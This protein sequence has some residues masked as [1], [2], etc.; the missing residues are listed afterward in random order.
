MLFSTGL[1]A[2]QLHERLQAMLDELE[3]LAIPHEQSPV[4]PHV[5]LS[6]GMFLTHHLPPEASAKALLDRADRLLYRAKSAGENRFF[7]EEALLDKP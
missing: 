5:M 4:S 1:D 2:V 6:V 3:K 7:L